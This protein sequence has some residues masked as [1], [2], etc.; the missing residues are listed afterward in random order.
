MGNSSS[1]LDKYP[2]P[3]GVFRNSFVFYDIRS[4][5]TGQQRLKKSKFITKGNIS[6]RLVL[7]NSQIREGLGFRMECK[8]NGASDES[9]RI[10]AQVIFHLINQ[11]DESRSRR[12]GVRYYGQTSVAFHHGMQST[13]FALVLPSTTI[14]DESQ[15]FLKDDK[16]ELVLDVRVRTIERFNSRVVFNFYE[17]FKESAETTQSFSSLKDIHTIHYNKT[18]PSVHSM[19][20]EESFAQNKC[21][22]WNVFGFESFLRV[23][24]GEVTNMKNIPQLLLFAE[25]CKVHTVKRKCEDFIVQ[26]HHPIIQEEFFKLA[27]QHNLRR[28]IVNFDQIYPSYHSE[29]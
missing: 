10:R 17:P 22:Q 28:V 20:F 9:W 13:G 24:H 11:L 15:G 29:F 6:C 1:Y 21:D 18:L 2:S 26:T 23:L 5:L 25:A 12:F 19:I 8:V 4:F 16:L 27:I 14:L 3:Y 7:L